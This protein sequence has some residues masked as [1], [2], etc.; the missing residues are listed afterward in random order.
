M[1]HTKSLWVVAGLML[2][3]AV[4]LYLMGRSVICPCG[5]VQLWGRFAET[6][7]S[8]QHLFDWYTPSHLLHGILF[9]GAL[10][11]VARRLSFGTRL[12]AATVVECI[13]EV[14]ENSAWV[15]DRY[16]THTVSFD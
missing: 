15:I 7:T 6:E 11:L 12:A 5:Y 13:W 8:S 4:T 10:W 3:T 9:Y 2:A 16:R 1:T 14:I